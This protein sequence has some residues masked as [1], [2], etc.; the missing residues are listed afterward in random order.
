MAGEIRHARFDTAAVFRRVRARELDFEHA[1]A[2]APGHSAPRIA[3][4]WPRIDAIGDHGPSGAEVVL[5]HRVCDRVAFPFDTHTGVAE[6]LLDGIDPEMHGADGAR[7]RARDRRLPRS[8][9]PAEGDQNGLSL[10]AGI[11]GPR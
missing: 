1:N 6:C 3:G 9:Q 2:R 5:R 8:G 4:Q 7:Q 11:T 10:P